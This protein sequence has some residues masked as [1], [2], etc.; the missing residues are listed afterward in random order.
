MQAGNGA[1][2]GLHVKVDTG[3]RRLGVP[4]AELKA[5]LDEIMAHPE[6]RVTALF[7]HMADSGS[8][9]AP[10]NAE[11][12]RTFRRA[13]DIATAE[14]GYRPEC[15]LAN[16]GGALHFPGLH[17]DAVRIGLLLFGI[18]PDRQLAELP[19]LPLRQCFTLSSEVIDLH[20]LQPGDGVSYCHSWVADRPTTLATLPFGYADGMPWSLANHAEVLIGGQRCPLR[21]NVCMDYLMADVGEAEV[22]LGDEAVFI[23]QQG[24]EVVRL[25]TVAAQAQTVPYE[26]TCRWGR[27]V[28]R[29]YEER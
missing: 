5:L 26:L 20:Q 16:S 27:R 23:G 19:P 4:V 21:G 18:W 1:P 22:H 10:V 8:P 11:Q 17:L 13:I 12:E 15:H 28:R 2:L 29:V 6:L 3:M 14:L 7:S 25:E 9:E 24:R